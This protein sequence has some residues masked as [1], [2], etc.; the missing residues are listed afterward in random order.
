MIHRSI[1]I[2][3]NRLGACLIIAYLV[4]SMPASHAEPVAKQQLAEGV[5]F[6]VNSLRRING[7]VL[8]MD[9]VI[10]NNTSK[11]LQP[12]TLGLAAPG[13]MNGVHLLDMQNLKLYKVGRVPGV[14]YLCSKSVAVPANGRQ[15]YFAQYAAP[16]SGVTKLA[17]QL[18]V[19]PPVFNV[20]IKP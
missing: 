14:G 12:E 8:Q 3:A 15:V 6:E 16:P 5:T 20:P 4:F 10:V 9:F 19:A 1:L 17:I 11:S 18:P 7:K 13:W 2:W